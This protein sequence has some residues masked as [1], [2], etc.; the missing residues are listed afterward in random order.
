MSSKF[1]IPMGLDSTKKMV[2]LKQIRDEDG[3]LMVFGKPCFFMPARMLLEIQSELE[4]KFPKKIVREI[5]EEIGRERT[6]KGA[7]FFSA[8]R[9][10]SRAFET[11]HLGSP[12]LEMGALSLSSTGWGDFTA[13]KIG[14]GRIIVRCPNSPFANAHKKEIGISKGPVCFMLCGMIAG[15]AE[16]WQ[17]KKC[18]A[19]EINCAATGKVPECVFEV[20]IE[21]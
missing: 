7:L 14:K 19:R 4:S 2:F 17:G 10:I 9:G 1:D 21:K 8:L 18:K 20:S 13:Q 6:H 16:V 3:L 12:L 11:L 15:A 5:F